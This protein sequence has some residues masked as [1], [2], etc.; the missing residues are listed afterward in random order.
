MAA[1]HQRYRI[2]N[3]N[4]TMRLLT[5]LTLLITFSKLAVVILFVALLPVLV[6]KIASRYTNI[7]LQEQKKKVLDIISKNG[8][9]YYFEGDSSYGSYTMLKEEYISLV[10]SPGANA[11]DTVET[12]KRIIENDTLNYRVLIHVFDY[13]HKKYTLEIGK[14]V[15]SIGEYNRL[16]QRFTLY[17]LIGLIAITVIIDLI[18]TNYLI[19][20]LG[21]IIK[22]K[23]LHRKFP[24]KEHL[25]PIKTTTSD[26]KYLDQSLIDLIGKIKEA[27]DKEREF[28]S[29]ASHELMTPISIL[30][31]NMENLM[32]N[33]EMDEELQEKITGMMKTLNRLKKIVHSLLFISRIENDQFIKT[34]KVK[35]ISLINEMT[36]E[37]NLR[38]EAKNIRFTIDVSQTV[39]LKNINHDLLFQL[40]YNLINNAIR[41]NKEEGQIIVSDNVIPGKSYTLM[42][43]DTGIGIPEKELANIFDRF[44]KSVRSNE[45]GYGLGLY[46]VKTIAQYYGLQ[47]DVQ[48]E[49]SKGTVFSIIFSEQFLS[50][51]NH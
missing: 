8:I 46:I 34:E 33:S 6:S 2:Q 19:R 9:N 14:T 7:N 26:F 3:K 45:E 24:F 37:L 31:T 41:Y 16:L 27:F 43:K 20:P 47:I 40:I 35:I 38:M 25:I 21:T 30:Q 39:V 51:A 42:I 13:K 29:N 18:F 28:T 1:N 5:K 49:I 44:K 15:A 36:E 12:S 23:L 10:L 11:I 48:S 50:S 22:T 4:L 17:I 32:I